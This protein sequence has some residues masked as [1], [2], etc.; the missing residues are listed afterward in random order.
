MCGKHA[1]GDGNR[2]A[3]DKGEKRKLKGGGVSFENDAAH[4]RL[5]F[6][7]LSQVTAHELP[8]IVCILRVKRRIQSERMTELRDLPRCCTLPEHLLDGITW[9]DVN[10]QKDQRKHEPERRECEQ[11][12]FEEVA[13]HCEGKLSFHARWFRIF[14]GRDR[15][16]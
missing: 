6:E 16:P 4:G 11:E 1:R 8:E 9:H 14:G 3:N 5:E 2:R 12:S 7:G 15:S 10:H 13:S